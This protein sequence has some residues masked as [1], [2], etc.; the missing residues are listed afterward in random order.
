M[1]YLYDIMRIDRKVNT[2]DG[3][4]PPTDGEHNLPLTSNR[5]FRKFQESGNLGG[6]KPCEE[7]EFNDCGLPGVQ[8]CEGFQSVIIQ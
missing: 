8:E 4:A 5:L 6:S 1:G 7:P 3:S 2:L